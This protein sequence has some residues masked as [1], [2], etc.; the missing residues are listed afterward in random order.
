MNIQ[1]IKLNIHGKKAKK[2]VTFSR[3]NGINLHWECRLIIERIAK[4]VITLY[5]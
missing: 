3:Q 4:S 5:G 1:I 2:E